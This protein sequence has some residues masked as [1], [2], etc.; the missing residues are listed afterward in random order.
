ME[1]EGPADETCWFCKRRPAENGAV[2]E[3]PMHGSPSYLGHQVV[4]WGEGVVR[5][6]RCSTCKRS[7]R[8]VRM[9]AWTALCISGAVALGI[10]MYSANP[11]LRWWIAALIILASM[12]IGFVVVRSLANRYLLGGTQPESAIRS[13]PRVQ[14]WERAGWRLGRA[15]RPDVR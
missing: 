5:V 9:I 11:R 8:V 4:L 6:P 2:Y 15:P 12:L 3:V 7:H 13:H 1:I 14:E 10:V